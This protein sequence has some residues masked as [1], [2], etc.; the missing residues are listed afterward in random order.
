MPP[1]FS[2]PPGHPGS[3]P[4]GQRGGRVGLETQLLRR[5]RDA[6]HQEVLV[7]IVA[8][9]AHYGAKLG[10]LAVQD[11]RDRVAPE[12][13][14][15]VQPVGKEGTLAASASTA[16]ATFARGSMVAKL[17][18]SDG[19]TRT[20]CRRVFMEIQKTRVKQRNQIHWPFAQVNAGIVQASSRATV[21]YHV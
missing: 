6:I 7:P 15:L 10:Q 20:S 18:M 19:G 5:L 2:P 12:A 21:Q 9:L 17:K 8:V 14:D 16:H 1:I 4:I 11:A 13:H 3:I